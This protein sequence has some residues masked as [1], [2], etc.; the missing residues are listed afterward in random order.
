VNSYTVIIEALKGLATPAIAFAG[1][2]IACA[3]LRLTDIRLTHDLFE[4]RYAIYAAARKFIQEI[5][6]KN[7]V[8]IEDRL[9]FYYASVDAIFVLDARLAAYLDKLRADANKAAALH[10]K[11]DRNQASPT[12]IEERSNLVNW[13]STQIEPLTE[14]FKP[15]LQYERLR[16]KRY[17]PTAIIACILLA[18]L[19]YPLFINRERARNASPEPTAA[20]V[21]HLRSECAALGQ[22]IL[23]S[24]PVNPST[25]E[26][27]I[28]HYEPRTNRCYVRL[29]RISLESTT[30]DYSRLLFDGQTGESLAFVEAKNKNKIGRVAKGDVGWEKANQ[31]IDEMMTD[32]RKQ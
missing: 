25:G 24:H 3:Q 5:C 31:F 6:Q 30:S 12:E 10:D 28:S 8:T 2:A 26:Y 7:T 19:S 1:I 20:E 32:D 4:R 16:W 23:D 17:L 15:F 11:I 29:D 9:S 22:K 14:N 21:F 27:Q 18:F 13:F